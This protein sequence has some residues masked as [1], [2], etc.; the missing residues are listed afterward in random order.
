MAK[1]ISF[2]D[3]D[4]YLSTSFLL[5]LPTVNNIAQNILS[6]GRGCHLAKVDIARA[7][8]HLAIDPAD[9]SLVGIRRSGVPIRFPPRF[10]VFSAP[11]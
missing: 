1:V 9:V 7:F 5:T 8:R 10:S 4:T 6:L 2:V 3:K 11:K